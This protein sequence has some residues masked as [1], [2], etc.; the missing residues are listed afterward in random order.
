MVM[1]YVCY[2]CG[3]IQLKNVRNIRTLD[4]RLTSCLSAWLRPLLASNGRA[5]FLLPPPLIDVA[6]DS[7]TVYLQSLL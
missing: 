3:E 5:C 7:K 4:L 2:R 6:V 1:L